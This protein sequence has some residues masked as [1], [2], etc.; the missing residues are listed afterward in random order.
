MSIYEQEVT[1]LNEIRRKPTQNEAMTLEMEL[2][3]LLMLEKGFGALWVVVG[4]ELE[5]RRCCLCLCQSWLF[6]SFRVATKKVR[7]K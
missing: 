3:M 6:V 4:V 5:S 7:S 1:T 2:E